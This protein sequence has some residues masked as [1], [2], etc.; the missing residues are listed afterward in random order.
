ML[1]YELSGRRVSATVF[2]GTDEA[3]LRRLRGIFH[4]DY[5]RVWLSTDPVGVEVFAAL[6]E[7]V[8]HRH[9]IGSRH[10]GSDWRAG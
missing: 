5:Y 1:A 7:R 10:V 9:R 6:E 2:T 8:H 4:N 3:E